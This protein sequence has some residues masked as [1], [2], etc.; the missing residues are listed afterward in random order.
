MKFRHR[1]VRNIAYALLAPY[2]WF[3]YG[4]KVER[5]KEQFAN[6]TVERITYTMPLASA[7]VPK[8]LQMTPI[9]WHVENADAIELNE[10]TIDLDILV[11]SY[12][13]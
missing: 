10:I 11:G 13:V 1:V 7:D 5:F 8:L 6:V 2:S 12:E 4:I 9:G 3:K